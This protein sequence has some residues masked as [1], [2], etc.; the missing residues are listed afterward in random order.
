Q[1]IACD[2]PTAVEKCMRWLVALLAFLGALIAPFA[3]TA[4]I[5]EGDCDFNAEVTI[6]ELVTLVNIALG[7]RPLAD[8]SIGD[9]DGNAEITI[10]EIIVAVGDALTS[11]ATPPTPTPTPVPDEPCPQQNP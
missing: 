7:N 2:A 1:P 4:I 11:C 6:E 9:A 5:C 10:D 3:A 8:C